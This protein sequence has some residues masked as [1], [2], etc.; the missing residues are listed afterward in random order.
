M[1]DNKYRVW[2]ANTERQKPMWLMGSYKTQIEA[3]DAAAR[4]VEEAGGEKVQFSRVTYSFDD[5][6]EQEGVLAKAANECVGAIIE[7]LVIRDDG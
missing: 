7:G 3:I 2:S 4:I 1:S 5:L 6:Q